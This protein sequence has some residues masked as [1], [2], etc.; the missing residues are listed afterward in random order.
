[1]EEDGPDPEPGGVLEAYLA[2]RDATVLGDV[3]G[4]DVLLDDAFTILHPT[5]VEQTKAEWLADLDSGAT[6]V[7][8]VDV[9]ETALRPFGT[10]A[11]LTVRTLTDATAWRVHAV[12][13]WQLRIDYERRD[14]R[15]IAMRAVVRSW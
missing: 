2:Q 7:H 13:R 4:L 14:D 15:W 3:D 11:V 9:V 10:R 8:D 5:G 6:A 12:W 1:M